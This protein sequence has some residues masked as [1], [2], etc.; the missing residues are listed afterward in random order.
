MELLLFKR[1]N[2][3]LRELRLLPGDAAPDGR[4]K[5]LTSDEQFGIDTNSPMHGLEWR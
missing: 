1:A 4:G 5:S 2:E 3:W